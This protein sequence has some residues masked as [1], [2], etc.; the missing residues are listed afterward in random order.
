[1]GNATGYQETLEYLYSSLPMFSS[2]GKDAIKPDLTNTLKL[3]AALG[4]P[5]HKFKSIHIAGT[6]GKGSTSHALA[7]ALQT[8]GYKTGLYTSPHLIDF[9]ERIRINGQPVSQKFIVDFVAN[10]KNLIEEVQPSFFE[11]NVAMAF[12]AFAEAGVDI[13]IIETGLGGRL[14]STNVITPLLSIITNISYDHKDILGNTLPEIAAEKAGIMKPNVPVIIGEQD[15][16]TERVFF[17]H[18]VQKQSPLYYAQSHWD[19]VRVK[20]DGKYQYYKAVDKVNQTLHDIR[21]DLSGNYQAH[22]IKTVLTAAELLGFLGFNLPIEH[23]ITALGDVKGITGLMGR[24]D[25]LQ[26]QP[27]IICD[28]AHNA[29]GLAEVLHQWQQVKAA[30][31]HIVVGFV[32][33]KDVNEALALFPKDATYYFCNAPTVRA[34]PAAE[35]QAKAAAI[36]LSGNTYRSTTGA[37]H[38]AKAAMNADDALLITGSFFIV[39]EVLESM[40]AIAQ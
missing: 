31:K 2:M 28:V 5:Q 10:T 18:S 37:F 24:W 40:A 23:V 27:V 39:G 1:M 20:Q 7:A 33:D 16:E 14:D 29:A 32:K 25:W 4:N 26:E 35:L 38:A 19:M 30:K 6:N 13:A 11:V 22:N 8:S 17:E 21:T 15:E 12:L 34:L 3:C 9:R 36:G